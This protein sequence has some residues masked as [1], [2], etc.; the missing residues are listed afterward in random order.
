MSGANGKR[1]PGIFAVLEVLVL[2]REMNEEHGLR[3]ELEYQTADY[4]LANPEV[5]REVVRRFLGVKQDWELRRPLG[6]GMPEWARPPDGANSGMESDGQ[7]SGGRRPF[8]LGMGGPM[9]RS[10]RG[11]VPLSGAQRRG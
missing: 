9:W 8:P 7:A 4:L 10:G 2:S 1:P 11:A 5:G 6:G 3:R